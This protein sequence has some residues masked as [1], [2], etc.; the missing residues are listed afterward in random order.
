M[1][2]L[3]DAKIYIRS[4]DGGSGSVSFR[5]EKYIPLGGPDGGDGGRGGSV[6]F[7]ADSH[8][9]TLIDF[10]YKQHF[11]AQR[12][13]NGMGQCRTGRSAPD[14]V[15]RV[16][17]GTILRN[18]ADGSVLCDF[19]HPGQTATLAE[20]GRG[21]QG[22]IHYKSSTNR[23]PR[24]SQPGEEGQEFWLR[25]ELKLLADVG[26]IGMPNAGKSTLI[27][28]VSAARPKIAGYPF[29]T[30]IPNLGVVRAGPESSFVMADIPGLV[31][32]ASTGHGLGHTFLKHV[33]RCAILVHL[34]EVMPLDDSDPVDNFKR[35]EQELA[36]YSPTLAAKPQ[37]VILSKCDLVSN[38]QREPILQRLRLAL[39][40]TG[41]PLHGISAVSGEGIRTWIFQLAEQ[42][43]LL[44][45]RDVPVTALEDAPTR[46]GKEQAISE[47]DGERCEIGGDETDGVQCFWV[48]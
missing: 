30:L 9:N 34:V 16:P 7:V 5:R 6:V 10:R 46:A 41:P 20:G 40:Q 14:L 43:H 33:E 31:E 48:G 18:D 13:V 24:Q 22:N 47:T 45:K 37:W 8:L 19:L 44:R 29:T 17:V 27:S 2:F 36:A 15:V 21:G 32:G 42:V 25:L 3:D 28:V 1:R 4:G 38:E 23:S 11:K 35:I 39:S 26:L 12:G